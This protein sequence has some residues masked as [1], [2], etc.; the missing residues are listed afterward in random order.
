MTALQVK[1]CPYTKTHSLLN[2]RKHRENHTKPHV[3]YF[4]PVDENV[5]KSFCSL[6]HG[7]KLYTFESFDGLS[8]LIMKETKNTENFLLTMTILPLNFIS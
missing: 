4:H 2:G 1:L 8:N 6:T 3:S 7:M 5:N